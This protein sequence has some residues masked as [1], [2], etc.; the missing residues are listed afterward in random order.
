MMNPPSPPGDLDL[1]A[2]D[3]FLLSDRAPDDGMGLS[4]LDGFLTGIVVGPELIMPSEWMPVIWDDEEPDFAD[5]NEAQTI[6]GTIMGRYNEII[7]DLSSEPS[8]LHPIYWET[9]DDLV[10]VSDWAAGF[11][12]AVNLRVNAWE[13]LFRHR[14]AKSLIV[15]LVALGADDPDE[16]PFGFPP[17][18]KKDME[19]WNAGAVEMIPHCVHGIQAF[20]QEWRQKAAAATFRPVRKAPPH[21]R[22]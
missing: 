7:T 6:L 16:P 20:W 19:V 11:L 15:P 17:F 5:L 9:K 18:E 13:P 1:E 3:A 14:R 12:D 22:R 2:L 21:R 8:L 10:I 4:D